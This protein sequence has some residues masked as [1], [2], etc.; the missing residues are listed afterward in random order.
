MFGLAV[1]CLLACATRSKGPDAQME[2]K[3][4]QLV[5]PIVYEFKVDVGVGDFATQSQT[6]HVIENFVQ[7]KNAAA[8]VTR[9]E[10]I[11]VILRTRMDWD[12]SPWQRPI[13][14]YIHGVNL[15]GYVDHID[16]N[17]Q[18]Q[19]WNPHAPYEAVCTDLRELTSALGVP[20]PEIVVLGRGHP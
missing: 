5:L 17:N 13:D 7:R 8:Q 1:C 15:L 6:R 3:Q 4:P 11:S 18:H 16:A 9:K 20:P 14:L 19:G 2:H 12:A 10:H